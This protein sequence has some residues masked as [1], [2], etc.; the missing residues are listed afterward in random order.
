MELQR[1]LIVP[2]YGSSSLPCNHETLFF[3]FPS[4]PL[5][6]SPNPNDLRFL[7]APCW[8]SESHQA[9]TAGFCGLFPRALDSTNTISPSR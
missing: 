2:K 1:L 3:P 4:P 6:P 7:D 8:V 5:H 9:R